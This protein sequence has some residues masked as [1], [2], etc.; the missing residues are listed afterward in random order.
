MNVP[1]KVYPTDQDHTRVEFT[2]TDVGGHLINLQYNGQN[3]VGSPFTAYTYDAARVRII[4]C[5]STGSVGRDCG[6]TGKLKILSFRL[7]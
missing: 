6:F 5:D 4:D 7:I 3:V 2:P 1:A